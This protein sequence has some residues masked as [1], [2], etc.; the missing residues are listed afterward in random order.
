MCCSVGGMLL[1]FVNSGCGR[2]LLCFCMCCVLRCVCVWLSLSG[3]VV[4]RFMMI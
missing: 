1:M 4:C 2:W 3:L